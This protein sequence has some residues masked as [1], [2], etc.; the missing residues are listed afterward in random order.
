[1]ITKRESKS[2]I[3]RTAVQQTQNAKMPGSL[4]VSQSRVC[5]AY[6]QQAAASG[7][8]LLLRRVPPVA[9]IAARLP[10]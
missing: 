6:V 2:K 5:A 9:S 10:G 8:P 3:E 7:R 4:P 1:M